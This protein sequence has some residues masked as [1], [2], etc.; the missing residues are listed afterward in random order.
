MNGRFDI[1]WIIVQYEVKTKKK[2][3]ITDGTSDYCD[4]KMYIF[5]L[6][7]RIINVS[8]Q[9]VNLINS[10]PKFKVEEL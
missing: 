2:L 4:D 9:T 1:E 6:L 7:F 3:G 10:L 5:N 8:I